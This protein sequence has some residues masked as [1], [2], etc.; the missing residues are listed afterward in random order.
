MVHRKDAD[1]S[2]FRSGLLHGVLSVAVF[3]GVVG[4][5]G[6]MVHLTGDPA[7]AGPKQVIAL[8]DTAEERAPTLRQRPTDGAVLALN[9]DNNGVDKIAS[10]EPNLGVADPSGAAPVKAARPAPVLTVNKPGGIRING[11]L[12]NPGESYSGVEADN[13]RPQATLLTARPEPIADKQEAAPAPAVVS[14]ARPF[15]NPQ[16][17]P[18]V[19]LIIGGLGTSRSQ[20]ITAIDELPPEVTLSFVPRARANLIRYAREKGHEVLLEIPMESHERGKTRPHNDR[21]LAS[22]PADQNI[23]RLKALLR[24]KKNL[25]GVITKRGDK[26]VTAKDAGAPVLAYLQD[27]QLAFFQHSGLSDT[28][29][30]ADAAALNMEFAAAQENIDTEL[31]SSEVEAQLLK[32]ETLALEN[33]VALGTGFSYPLTADIVSRWSRRLSDKGILLAPAS[34]V[35]LQTKQSAAFQTSLLEIEDSGANADLQ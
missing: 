24:G 31:R 8:F 27:N 17:K 3:G 33:G 34:A 18:I 11:K 1:P 32:L 7:N 14:Y 6:G 28:T 19:S 15:E 25:Y 13:G 30:A 2:P 20:T 5:L 16:G 4:L 9:I 26:F 22:V 23:L 29:F 21:L 35:A 10:D 12:V